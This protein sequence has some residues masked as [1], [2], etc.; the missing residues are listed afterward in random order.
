[1][2]E[3]EACEIYLNP[4]C[5]EK[6]LIRPRNEDRSRTRSIFTLREADFILRSLSSVIH[7]SVSY[8]LFEATV[9]YNNGHS[10]F[11]RF[12]LNN[13]DSNFPQGLFHRKLQDWLRAYLEQEKVKKE[14]SSNM[15]NFPRFF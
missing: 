11:F 15:L 5:I 14:D 7:A 12:P 10:L 13:Q 8:E 1:M 9:E 6:I 3:Q 4:Q 2:T